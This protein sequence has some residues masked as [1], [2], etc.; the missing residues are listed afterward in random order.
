MSRRTFAWIGGAV[1]VAAATALATLVV[2][3]AQAADQPLL[4]DLRQ[5]PIGC[6][7]G[8]DG[9][10][11]GCTDWDVCPVLDASAPNGTCVSSG[12]IQAVRLRFTSSEEN[13]GAGPLL[14]YGHRADT[15]TPRMAVRQAFQNGA[16]GPIPRS[17]AEAQHAISATTYYEPAAMHQHWHLLEFDKFALRTQKGSTVVTDRKNGFCLGDRYTAPSTAGLDAAPQAGTPEGDLAAKLAESTCKRREPSALDVTEGISV[18]QGDNYDY[19]VDFQWLDITGVASGTYTVVNTVNP[20][21][22]ITESDYANNSSSMAVSVRWPGGGPAPKVIVAPPVV[23]L[24]RSCPGSA[25]C[26]A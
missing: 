3:Q 4:P 13:V 21:R 22:S 16:H 17:F 20:D 18:G 1:A 12:S 26:A 5:A 19:T 23:K 8:Y 15:D 14:L 9:D 7:A 24:L 11:M 2:P 10:P 6:A 25:G